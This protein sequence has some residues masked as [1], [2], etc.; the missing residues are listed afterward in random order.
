M[1]NFI[2]PKDYDASI[3]REIL[4]SLLREK[5]AGGQHNPLY[6]PAVVETCEDRA[7]AEMRSYLSKTYDCDAIF[8]ARGAERHQLILMYA[9]DIAI[10]HIFCLHNPYKI[11]DIRKERYERATDWLESV[12]QG[13]LSIEGAPR[14]SQEEVVENSPWQIVA[15]KV[16]P[17]IM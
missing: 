14:R 8:S 3:H 1:S 4:S 16:R 6:D 17:T 5:G 15:D 13:K 9:L 10:Y 12:A 11:A 7:I 2:D